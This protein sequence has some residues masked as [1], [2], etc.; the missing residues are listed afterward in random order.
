MNVIGKKVQI[1]K[2][3]SCLLAKIKEV[4]SSMYSTRSLAAIAVNRSNRKNEMPKI[5]IDIDLF[6]V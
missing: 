5:E 6:F 3:F 1:A 2:K 4:T